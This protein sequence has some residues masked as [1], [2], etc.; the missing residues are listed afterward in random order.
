L[1]L[2]LKGI[3]YDTFL[4][5]ARDDTYDGS[6]YS[7]I[8]D[9]RPKRL[10]N[11]AMPQ[12]Q[13][14]EKNSR[15]LHCGA[16][17]ATSLDLLQQLDVAFPDST[18]LW[19][20]LD[21]KGR[22]ACNAEEVMAMA[23]AFGASIP[24]TATRK[25]SR[26]AWIFCREE[27]YRLDAL[28]RSTFETFLDTAEE[29]LGHKSGPF[30]CGAALSAADVV[31]APLL[32]RYA[33]QL[34]CLYANLTPRGGAWPKLEEWYQ[35]MDRVPP[36]VCRIKGDAASWRKV[37]FV[38]PWWPKADLWH[39]RDTVGPKGELSLSEEECCEAF[40]DGSSSNNN[41]DDDDIWAEYTKTRPHV[42]PDGPGS[43]AA[44]ALIR[45]RSAI[46]MDAAKWLD[47]EGYPEC[48]SLNDLDRALRAIAACVSLQECDETS[49]FSSD[50]DS[51]VPLLLTY[52]VERVCVPRDMGA[53]SA[54][55]IR[56]LAG[57][58]SF[59]ERL[60]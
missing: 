49:N 29:L 59:P 18:P 11:L 17:E 50:E 6:V 42:S 31:W 35:A 60:P 57:R 53:P 52:L 48:S 32:E 54:A 23:K 28:L 34:P 5:E 56:K 33:T 36:Y 10:N 22:P 14:P 27:G 25:S 3:D 26:A 43:E 1:A 58:H 7:G 8:D 40:L 4:V 20:P 16:T 12:L 24:T 45:N 47:A 19:P 55:A 44:L 30:F 9:G 37:L 38:D 15:Q 46:A 13:F 21:S 41:L 39:P 2:E 51:I